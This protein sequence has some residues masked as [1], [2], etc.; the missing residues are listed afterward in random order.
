MCRLCWNT[1][2]RKRTSRMRQR[3]S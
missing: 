1:S 2:I 3:Q